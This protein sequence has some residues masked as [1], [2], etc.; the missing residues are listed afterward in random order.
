MIELLDEYSTVLI[1]LTV[2]DMCQNRKFTTP[3]TI[4]NFYMLNRKSTPCELTIKDPDR[5][6]TQLRLE[7][8]SVHSI[9]YA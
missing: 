7:P 2:R 6:T 4:D 5:G 1:E 3:A 8:K 9:L